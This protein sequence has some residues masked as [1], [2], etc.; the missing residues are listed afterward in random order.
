M[1]NII[2]IM[3]IALTIS[4]SKDDETK[5]NENNT[6]TSSTSTSNSLAVGTSA[7]GILS[8]TK[9]KSLVVDLVY[10]AG[11]EPTPSA[12]DNLVAF[13]EAR[14]NKPNGITVQKREIAT[15]GLSPYS[16]AD[17]INVEANFRTIF[18]SENQ[19]AIWAFFADGTSSNTNGNSVV[20]GT[21][22]RNTSF[23]I[24]E[25]SIHG[26]SD[27]PFEPDR[28]KLEATVIRHEFGHL[29]G[30]TNLGTP[31]QTAHEDAAHPKHCDV[32][33]CLMFWQSE[34]GE[35]VLNMLSGGTIPE[36]DSQ[37]ILDLQANGGK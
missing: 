28:D 9:F 6:A 15:P 17:L 33:N 14:T 16:Q 1:K 2:F 18:S 13:L 7:N 25:E 3:F 30:L 26:F 29:F 20:L 12:V 34:T 24:Y 11:F 37:C 5:A 35:G 4:C 36:L 21:A 22:Y 23:V 32:E 10:V 31:L 19:I 27:S 8:A